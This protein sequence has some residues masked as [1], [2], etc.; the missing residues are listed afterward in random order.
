MTN[1]EYERMKEAARDAAKETGRS[2]RQL[3]KTLSNV[4]EEDNG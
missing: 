2:V 3:L 4:R 1:A